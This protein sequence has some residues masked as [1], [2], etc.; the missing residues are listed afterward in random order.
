M[1]LLIDM[2]QAMLI[3]DANPKGLNKCQIDFC[4]EASSSDWHAEMDLFVDD[5]DQSAG[6]V[7]ARPIQSKVNSAE[8]Y[9]QIAEWLDQCKDHIDCSRVPSYMNL[10]SRVIEVAPADSL[11][12]P[13]I[14]STT[15]KKGLYLAL[16]YCW[17]Y[18]QSYV[19]TTKNLEGFMRELDVNMLP[20]T[21]SDAI[22]VT[23]C[24][25]FKYLWVDALCIMQDSAEAAA[26]YD[27]NQEL[28]DMD[29]VY[30]NATMTYVEASS[31]WVRYCFIKDRPE[32]GQQRFDIPC[33]LGPSHFFTVHIQEQMLYT[34]W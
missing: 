29:Q 5:I 13:R 14:R 11:D 12:I 3:H 33:R 22:Q 9:A 31:S 7:T 21:I 30:K 15:G 28:A 17:G 4:S 32:S 6:I 16:S 19:L 10:P 8:A 26:R 34:D 20:R 2:E 24:L 27:M 1:D 23:K 18:S 25:G